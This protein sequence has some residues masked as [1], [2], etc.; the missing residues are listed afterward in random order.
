MLTD[1]REI[2]SN[3]QTALEQLPQGESWDVQESVDSLV[4]DYISGSGA[5]V[6]TVHQ[7]FDERGRWTFKSDFTWNWRDSLPTPRQRELIDQR[8]DSAVAVM[9]T[10]VRALLN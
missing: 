3:V 6:I 1:L 10:R 2:A 7:I 5:Y 9:E 8:I 4:A